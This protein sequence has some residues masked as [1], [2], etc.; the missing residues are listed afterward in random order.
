MDTD[1]E[2]RQYILV[3]DALLEQASREQLVEALKLLALNLGYLV[4]RH[5]DVPQDL[6]LRMTT[7]DTLTEETRDLV[8]T[9][10]RHL[11]GLLG[12]VMELGDENETRH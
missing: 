12:S 2:F 3:A 8:I 7:A 11:L 10:M 6:L 5:G 1:D 4:Q 9:G